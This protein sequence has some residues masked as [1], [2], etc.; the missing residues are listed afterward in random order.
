MARL[1]EERKA[2]RKDHPFVR[3]AF[4]LR[5]PTNTDSRLFTS[6][7]GLHCAPGQEHGPDSEFAQLGVRH[8]RQERRKCDRVQATVLTAW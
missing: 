6:V 7:L 4:A 1:A 3:D 5:V 8:S 2:W